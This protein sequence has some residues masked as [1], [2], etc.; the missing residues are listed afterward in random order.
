VSAAIEYK[1]PVEQ[2]SFGPAL[3]IRMPTGSMIVATLGSAGIK[4]R[5]VL[6]PHQL[7]VRTVER[8]MAEDGVTSILVIPNTGQWREVA[9]RA[10]TADFV[11]RPDRAREAYA[12]EV[13]AA[14]QKVIDK[15]IRW[16]ELWEAHSNNE[17]WA[18]PPDQVGPITGDLSTAVNQL[19]VAMG[20][21]D[22]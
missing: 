6:L 3:D 2:T 15:A 21:R 19:L 9:K 1:V 13:D 17:G 8:L 10:G 16:Y 7:Y 11:Q 12:P 22:A 18:P 20:L 5:T 4:P 14:R